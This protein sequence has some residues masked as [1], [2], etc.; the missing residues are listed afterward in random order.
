MINMGYAKYTDL[1]VLKSLK[2]QGEDLHRSRDF[3][4]EMNIKKQLIENVKFLTKDYRIDEDIYDETGEYEYRVFNEFDR[5]F[6]TAVRTKNLE[7]IKC[8]YDDDY[9]YDYGF[10]QIEDLLTTATGTGNL[11]IIKYLLEENEK[12]A[13]MYC[14]CKSRMLQ[15]AVVNGYIDIVKY[16]TESSDDKSCVNFIRDDLE[17]GCEYP[18]LLAISH[19]ELEIVEYLL[20]KGANIHINN[21]SALVY[22]EYTGNVELADFLVSKGANVKNAIKS[23][24]NPDFKKSLRR[25]L[26]K[27]EIYRGDINDT[28]EKQC[29]ICLEEMTSQ[30]DIIQCNTC[31]KCI[32]I[33]CSKKWN[34]DCVYCRS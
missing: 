28:T 21:D 9:I 14:E 32:H 29:A 30:S 15:T 20:E 5:L 34:G 4:L 25:Y 12:L 6:K 10:Y 1:E 3:I 22:T 23:A 24:H 19:N 26:P 7:L 27:K 16:I 17:E 11:E 31:K 18:L 33:E 8:I 13:D 2:E